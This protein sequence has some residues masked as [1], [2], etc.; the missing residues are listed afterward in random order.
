MINNKCRKHVLADIQTF[1]WKEVLWQNEISLSS[2]RN[3]LHNL[4]NFLGR[5][6]FMKRYVLW[7]C[8]AIFPF[9]PFL[10]IYL[11][12]ICPVCLCNSGFHSRFLSIVSVISIRK[13]NEYKSHLIGTITS[14]CKFQNYLFNYIQLYILTVNII[15]IKHT[16]IIQFL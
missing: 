15:Y 13:I 10:F 12:D 6:C 2:G 4:E 16:H 8:V 14:G 11:S 9:S 3:R 5:S 1:R 7:A